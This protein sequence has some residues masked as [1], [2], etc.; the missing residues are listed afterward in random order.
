MVV[1]SGALFIVGHGGTDSGPGTVEISLRLTKC[2]LGSFEL[3]LECLDPPLS[4]YSQAL[5]ILE[6]C[7]ECCLIEERVFIAK[8]TLFLQGLA[9]LLLLPLC[10]SQSNLELGFSL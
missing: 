3:A 2:A 10:L 5:L 7:R 4:C 8:A 9:R 6:R 1:K